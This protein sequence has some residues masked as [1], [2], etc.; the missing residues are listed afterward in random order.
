VIW[1]FA[2]K[3]ELLAEPVF[4]ASSVYFVSGSNVVYSLDKFSGQQKWIYARSET[5]PISLRGGGRPTL[6]KEAVLIGM[7][8]GALV[9]LDKSAGALRWEK[10]LN[11]T[12]KIRD[13]DS[14]IVIDNE[15]AYVMSYGGVVACLRH[16]TGDLV[17]K[18]D[19]IGGP[20]YMLSDKKYLYFSSADEQLIQLNKETQEKKIIFNFKNATGNTPILIDDKKVVVSDSAGRVF[21][22]NLETSKQLALYEAGTSIFTNLVYNPSEESIYFVTSESNLHKVRIKNSGRSL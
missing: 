10:Q 7:A 13:I 20:G 9:S 18:I 6:T 2:V 15:F 5:Q 12:R 4:D 8:D 3:S 19:K 1:S 17:W 16:L 11:S 22:V 14:N 21:L